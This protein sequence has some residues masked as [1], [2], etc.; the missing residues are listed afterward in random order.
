MWNPLGNNQ[1]GY[2][3]RKMA[4]GL[5]RAD[6]FSLH[7]AGLTGVEA[8]RIVLGTG[9]G[10]V[11]VLLDWESVHFGGA[12]PWFLCPGCSSRRRFLRLYD[13]RIGCTACLG[14]IYASP[15][16]RWTGSLPLRR[17]ARLRRRLG[18][19]VTPFSAIPSRPRRWS[20]RPSR[21]W[22]SIAREIERCEA[23][24]LGAIGPA[25]IAL[26]KARQP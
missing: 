23:E 2:T 3:P 5:A 1:Y 22:E 24:V 7:R 26:T 21:K 16:R 12:R 15:Y 19:D 14:L 6:I 20:T 9:A 17:A 10:E 4:D 25:Y 18:I 11:V 13:G 8:D